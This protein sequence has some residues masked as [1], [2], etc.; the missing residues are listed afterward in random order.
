MLNNIVLEKPLAVIDLET[1]GVDVKTD[2]IVEI[3]VLKIQPDG[4]RILRTRRLNPG[5]PIPAEATA[6]HGITDE[7]VAG[8][9]RFE[10]LAG[11][12]LSLLEGCDLCGFNLKRFD[13]RLLYSEF[14]RAGKTLSLEGRAIVD[15]MEIF[16]HF[17]RRDLSAAVR[18]H[19]GR[20]HEE[21]HSAS[22]DVVATVEVLDAMV[23]RYP[24]L[25]RSVAGLHEQFTDKDR[26]GSD[27]FFHRVQGEVRFVKGKHRGEALATVAATSRD[28]L[29]WMLNQDFF[30][31]TK[32]LV[33]D[34]LVVRQTTRP[35]SRLITAIST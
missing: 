24:G 27:G 17:E 20:E 1:T 15:P 12:L 22:A 16:H 32:T 34:A 26:L 21:A 7:D 3:S 29:E 30:D 5:I 33:R 31:D 28:Y 2:R 25:P 13:L 14:R 19:L 11:G 8:E 35:A 23:L 9:P 18:M 10:Q 6:I 4:Q